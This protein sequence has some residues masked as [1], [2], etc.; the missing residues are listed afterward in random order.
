MWGFI[1]ST[2][3][4]GYTM[5]RD[6]FLFSMVNPHG[7][8]PTK[9]PLKSSRQ[10]CAIL[11]NGSYGPTFG[12]GYDLCITDNTKTDAP[13]YSYLGNTYECPPGQ[14]STFFTGSTKFTVT[15]YEVFGLHTWQQ[16]DEWRSVQVT[17]ILSQLINSS[18]VENRI[19]MAEV[20]NTLWHPVV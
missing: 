9:S 1:W 17:D 10:Q 18:W 19:G 3:Q 6:A 4:R 14:K 13:S 8:G 15:D 16:T 7:L 5:C 20:Y 12:G 2:A 11:S